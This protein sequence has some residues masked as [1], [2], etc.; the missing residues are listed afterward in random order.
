MMNELM[1][2]AVSVWPS[3]WSLLFFVLRCD[4]SGSVKKYF[5]STTLSNRLSRPSFLVNFTKFISDRI[6]TPV[7]VVGNPTSLQSD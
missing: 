7:L 4:P 2:I 6:R 1:L 5:A 3:L